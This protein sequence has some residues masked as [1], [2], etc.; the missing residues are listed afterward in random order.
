MTLRYI[1][2]GSHNNAN[3]N[4]IQHQ[5]IRHEGN[6]QHKWIK[7]CKNLRKINSLKQS[8]YK[9]G[10]IGITMVQAYGEGIDENGY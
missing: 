2:K 4:K 10:H 6:A 3:M 1:I 9:T 8:N 5:K 7:K